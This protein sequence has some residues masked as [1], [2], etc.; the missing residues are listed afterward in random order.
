[1]TRHSLQQT[2]A[3]HSLPITDTQLTDL[4]T[5]YDALNT[6]P[7]VGPALIA[8]AQTSHVASVVFSNGTNAMVSNS[9]RSSPSLS[10]HA[11]VF[12]DLVT[13]DEV[14]RYKPDA[15]VYR[16]LARRTGKEGQMGDIWLVSGNPFDIVGA[17]AVGMKAAWVDRGGNGW[18]DKLGQG[19]DI[20]VK[21]L[22]E[23]VDAVQ[24]H[25]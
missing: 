21:G 9:V 5:A 13:V 15:E 20:T 19:P 3:E 22:G 17:K 12:K 18:V 16:H 24:R 1:M 23:V 6:F 14:Q 8:L 25:R 10:P 7:D 11:S 2:L 4:M